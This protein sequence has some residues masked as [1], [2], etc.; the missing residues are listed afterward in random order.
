MC[1]EAS[2]P[3]APFACP[4]RDFRQSHRLA[5]ILLDEPRTQVD[6]DLNQRFAPDALEA[7]DLAGLDDENVPSTRLELFSIH[8]IAAPAFSDELNLIIR[9]PMGTRP[10]TGLS[11]EQKNRNPDIPLIRSDELMRASLERKIV[12]PNA[13]HTGAILEFQATIERM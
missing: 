3:G 9:V 11:P 12:L 4:K 8:D 10:A 2:R 13:M 6:V 5:Q 7:V 1:V